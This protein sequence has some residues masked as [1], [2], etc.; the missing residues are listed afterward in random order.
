[1]LKC[2]VAMVAAPWAAFLAASVAFAQAPAPS[3]DC[4]APERQASTPSE[5]GPSS[6]TK[7]GNAGSTGWSGGI[8]GTHMDTTPSGPRPGSEQQHP[9]TAQGLDPIK[10][11][12]ENPPTK[13]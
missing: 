5:E 11:R 4:A 9:P 12:P 10:P 1:M 6:G 3:K 7:P 13:C 8:G 2:A